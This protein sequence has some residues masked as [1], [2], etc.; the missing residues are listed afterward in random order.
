MVAH[1][2]HSSG[3]TD[4]G[5]TKDMEDNVSQPGELDLTIVE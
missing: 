3:T 2:Y 1:I 5:V 4:E